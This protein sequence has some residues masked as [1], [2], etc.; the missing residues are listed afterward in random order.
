ML[1]AA[2]V[3]VRSGKNQRRLDIVIEAEDLE[4]AKEKAL[5]Q[6]R[7]MYMPGKKALY[8]IVEIINEADAYQ[9]LTHPRPLPD[10]AA[11]SASDV[12]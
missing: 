4:T 5:K 11:D 8:T 3:K 7:K 10:A 2:S 6:A 1:F 12:S 9:T